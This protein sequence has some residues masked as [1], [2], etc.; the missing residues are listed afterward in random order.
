MDDAHTLACA[1]YVLAETADTKELACPDD[2]PMVLA[3]IAEQFEKQL[4]R[5]KVSAK[6]RDLLANYRVLHDGVMRAAFLAAYL[7]K[8]NL[9]LAQLADRIPPFGAYTQDVVLHVGRAAFMRAAHRAGMDTHSGK[10]RFEPGVYGEILH[11]YA[12][13]VSVESAQALCEG[14]CVQARRLDTDIK[15][16][17]NREEAF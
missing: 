9:T 11:V 10:L 3:S 2:A 4:I 16:R 1:F 14:F 12:E 6:A 5:P 8:N 13:S 17:K 15:R 7:S